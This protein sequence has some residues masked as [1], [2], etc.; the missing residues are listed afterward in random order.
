LHGIFSGFFAKHESKLL[1]H[2]FAFERN[3]LQRFDFLSTRLNLS[4]EIELGLIEN[5][6]LKE[7]IALV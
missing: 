7:F 4:T 2:F 5:N 1:R 6:C 3:D